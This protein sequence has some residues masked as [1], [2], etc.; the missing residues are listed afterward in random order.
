LETYR[1]ELLAHCY[2]MTGSFGDA[3]D[4]LQDGFVRA[5]RALP[6]FEGRASLRTWLYRVVTSACL[7]LVAAHR[8]RTL[9][10][11]ER[12]DASYLEPFPDALADPDERPDAHYARRESIRLAFVIAL[13]LLPARQRANLLLRDVVA[14]SAD[15]AAAALDI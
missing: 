7:D 10:H 3:E 14:M 15:E 13:Q 12:G 8:A 1:R 4:A 5:W 9:P 6:G 2:R 11:L